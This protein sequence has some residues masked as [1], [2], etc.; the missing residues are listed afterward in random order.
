MRE[1]Q[2]LAAIY[3]NESDASVIDL[4]EAN[5]T[6]VQSEFD[7]LID[8]LVDTDPEGASMSQAK[9]NELKEGVRLGLEDFYRGKEN[10]MT[11]PI[12]QQ[13]EE[14]FKDI[15]F[16]VLQDTIE[17]GVKA[18]KE[19]GRASM[20]FQKGLQT[21]LKFKMLL[22][23]GG[24]MLVA[25]NI[26]ALIGIVT[27][28]LNRIPD[29]FKK[30]DVTSGVL[31][32][33][34]VREMDQTMQ[35]FHNRVFGEEGPLRALVPEHLRGRKV[36]RE[37][38]EEEAQ[39]IIERRQRLDQDI[40]EAD[41]AIQNYEKEIARWGEAGADTTAME[42]Q[43]ALA[44]ERRDELIARRIARDERDAGIVRQPS[45]PYE[46]LSDEEKVSIHRNM[47]QAITRAQEVG[48]DTVLQV[49]QGNKQKLEEVMDPD[50]LDSAK[51]IQR[52]SQVPPDPIEVYADEFPDHE[53]LEVSVNRDA[54]SRD[55]DMIWDGEQW[56]DPSTRAATNAMAMEKME[57]DLTSTSKTG[58]INPTSINMPTN[59]VTN[60]N[61]HV[62]SPT[63]DPYDD[64]RT[65]STYRRLQLPFGW[66]R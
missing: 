20:L 12:V 51:A 38:D 65:F 21:L 44:K 11:S 14:T 1:S 62:V 56:R 29:P 6:L 16:G 64:D 53:P 58:T 15:D 28:I 55:P 37:A 17:E 61:T 5:V 42:E 47:E 10:L 4:R 63:P 9:I 50:L 57:S 30:G 22:L 23:I 26:E 59:V 34:R 43:L 7:D 18:T 31:S 46:G 3:E 13:L 41:T 25:K 48:D 36:G 66:G 52:G 35:N 39:R 49:L 40:G 27:N 8:R 19:Q 2:L 33:D 32:D 24:I 60:N 45:N 54:G